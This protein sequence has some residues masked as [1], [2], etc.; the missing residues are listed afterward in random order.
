MITGVFAE[1]RAARGETVGL[2]FHAHGCMIFAHQNG[3]A[4]GADALSPAAGGRP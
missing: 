3:A 1:G 4:A 2:H